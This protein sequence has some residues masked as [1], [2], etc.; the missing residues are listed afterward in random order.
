MQKLIVRGVGVIGALLFGTFLY[1]TFHTPEF[2]EDYAKN[3]I[4]AQIAKKTN[5]KIE[6][7]SLV[8]K[9]S[10]L[11]KLAQGMFERN[12]EKIDQYKNN[13]STGLHNKIAEITAEMRNL[14]CECRDKF[15]KTLESNF[16][17]NI[18]ALDTLNLK[19]ENFMRSQYMSVS[20]ELRKEI[21]IFTGTNT[22]V[23]LLLI[24]VSLFKPRAISHLFL[25]AIL[26]VISTLTCSYFYISEQ[27]W[28]LTIIYSDYVG[29][30]YLVYIG[31]VFAFLSDIVFNS[32]EITTAILN[33]ILEGLGQAAFLVP[34]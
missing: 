9:E 3:F 22:L 2:V 7:I 16:R 6:Q 23:F 18:A 33:A 26:L 19:L 29:M 34:C 31:I 30:L 14:D 5:E 25:P 4:K 13:L 8:G 10:R 15:A 28:L 27:N 11:G 20:A 21:R 17:L 1:L 32:A 24:G 12:Q